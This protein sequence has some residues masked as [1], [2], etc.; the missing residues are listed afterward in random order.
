MYL[1][2]KQQWRKQLGNSNSHRKSHD[3]LYYQM[4]GMEDCNPSNIT[5]NTRTQSESDLLTSYHSNPNKISVNKIYGTT[6][7]LCDLSHNSTNNFIIK[8]VR[9]NPAVRVV[10][11]PTVDEYRQAGLGNSMWY[12]SEEHNQFKVDAMN[13]LKLFMTFHKKL[14]CKQSIQILYQTDY[15]EKPVVKISKDNINNE[16]SME[17]TGD[18]FISVSDGSDSKIDE[19]EHPSPSSVTQV[20]L[21]D[22]KTSNSNISS[23]ISKP[24][25]SAANNKQNTFNIIKSIDYKDQLSS[26]VDSIV[27]KGKSYRDKLETICCSS[28]DSSSPTSPVVNQLALLC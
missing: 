2:S 3:Y 8:K 12:D 9:L 7:N 18:L 20:N 10:L 22:N 4:I 14:T 27:A 24:N 5:S 13:E 19:S 21:Q 16:T 26:I 6:G 23:N 17:S 1:T 15:L 25:E 28:T 11:I